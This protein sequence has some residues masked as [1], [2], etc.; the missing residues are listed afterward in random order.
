MLKMDCHFFQTEGLHKTVDPQ[1]LNMVN[2]F[3]EL[4]HP[5]IESNKNGF[6]MPFITC[7]Y[8]EQGSVQMTTIVFFGAGNH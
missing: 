2:R 1:T 6:K 4:F 3:Q 5:Q 8:Y 7:I